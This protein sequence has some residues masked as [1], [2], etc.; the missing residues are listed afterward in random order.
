M[1]KNAYARYQ[2]ALERYHAS[3][4]RYDEEIRSVHPSKASIEAESAFMEKM[5]K[6]NHMQAISIAIKQDVVATMMKAG[7]QRQRSKRA[8]EKSKVIR[9]QTKDIKDDIRHT[10]RRIK[11]TT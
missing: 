1:R 2:D 10:E 7:F 5:A 8:I 3:L 9:A 6:V 11:L 4:Q